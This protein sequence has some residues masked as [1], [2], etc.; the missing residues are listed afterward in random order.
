MRRTDRLDLTPLPAAA[1][2]ALP[3]DRETASALLGA[4]LPA[5]WPQ[6]DLL[7]IL[8]M[9]A[10]ADPEGEP[11]GIWVMVERATNGLVGDI[12]FMG[13]PADGIVEIGFSVVPERRRLGF[14]SEAAAAVVEWALGEPSV[15]RVVARCD[16]DNDASI[17]VLERAGFVRTAEADGVIHWTTADARRAT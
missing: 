5:S 16:S 9:P 11:Y 3:D 8:P 12:G 13:P 15:D 10:S 1:A 17:G 6:A 4:A 7:D 2:A 14:A